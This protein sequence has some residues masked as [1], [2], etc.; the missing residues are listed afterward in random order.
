VACF[1]CGTTCGEAPLTVADRAFCCWG[2]QTVHELLQ[3]HGLGHYYE[4][5]EAPGVRRAG[6]GTPDRYAYLNDPGT[7]ERLLEFAGEET[8]RVTFSVPAIHCVACVWLLEQV[9]RFGEGIGSSTV[10]FAQK[11]VSIRF[12]PRRTTLARVAGLLDSLGYAPDLRLSDLD[13]TSVPAVSRR[14]W[15]QLGVAG[16]ALATRCCSACRATLVSMPSA[17][18]PSGTSLGS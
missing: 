1:H 9:F 16:F 11:R 14:L 4:L 7:R 18:L 15:L 12:D 10:D 6:E 2:C 3:E 13:R 8:C 17:G 5:G